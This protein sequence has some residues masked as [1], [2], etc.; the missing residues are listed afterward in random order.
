MI[1]ICLLYLWGGGGSRKVLCG[2]AP[3]WGPTLSPFINTQFLTQRV[4]LF[5]T[6]QWSMEPVH[7]PSLD[8]CIL[9]NCYKY[10]VFEIWR[11][12]KP[13]HFFFQLFH[14]QNASVIPF[15]PSYTDIKCICNPYQAFLHTKKT[16]LP[17]PFIGFRQRVKSLLFL[18]C[19]L[20]KVALWG[21]AFL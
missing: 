5:Y 10:A 7:T 12:C 11:E 13:D 19:S 2:D 17:Y 8:L 16:F 9:L 20:R 1:F 21:G 14:R 3:H 18:T 4:A 6:F 15:R